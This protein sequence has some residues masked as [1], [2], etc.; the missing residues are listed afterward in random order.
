MVCQLNGTPNVDN[1]AS[2][3]STAG[4][5]DD[6]SRTSAAPT[7]VSC[8]SAYGKSSGRRV[9]ATAAWPAYSARRVN[10]RPVWPLAPKITMRM[11]PPR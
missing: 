3:P 7:T 8:G 2:A 10:S 9:T 11:T 1:T 5:N 4:T 6:G